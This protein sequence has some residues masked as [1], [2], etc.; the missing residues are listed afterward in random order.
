MD[1]PEDMWAWAHHSPDDQPTPID[2]SAVLAVLV[3]HNAEQW[4]GRTL[5]GIARMDHQPGRL[6]AVD[7]GSLDG[8]RAL[9]DKGVH[10]GL[11]HTVIDG[12]VRM[13]DRELIGVDK[14][15]VLARCREA[16]Q[17]LWARINA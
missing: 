8:S 1:R 15:A 5:V 4:L 2:A 13:K 12:K 7:A 6:V 17:G 10:D 11:I 3:A 9:L 16:A 14:Q